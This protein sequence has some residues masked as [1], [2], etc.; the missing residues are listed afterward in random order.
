M[1]KF[2]IIISVIIYG[3]TFAEETTWVKVHDA[4]D[5]TWYGH[6]KQ[7]GEVPDGSENYLKV[8]LHYTIG[9]A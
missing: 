6:Y 1:R 5:M 8:M 3:Q 9:C 7:W 2:L 4:T